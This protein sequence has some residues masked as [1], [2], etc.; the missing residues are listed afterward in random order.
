ML[1]KD[2][3][4]ETSDIRSLLTDLKTELIEHF[5]D[6]GLVEVLQDKVIL[7]GK[8]FAA[9]LYAL[10]PDAP[11]FDLIIKLDADEAIEPYEENELSVEDIINILQPY[12]DQD[13]ASQDFTDKDVAEVMDEL[14][15]DR[16]EARET[17]KQNLMESLLS[18]PKPQSQV[19][20][21]AWGRMRHLAGLKRETPSVCLSTSV[22]IPKII[23]QTSRPATL[24][25]KKLMRSMNEELPPGFKHGKYNHILRALKREYG[26]GEDNEVVYKTAWRIYDAMRGQNEDAS[27]LHDPELMNEYLPPHF[28]VQYPTILAK[29]EKHYGNDRLGLVRGAWK[30]FGDTPDADKKMRQAFSPPQKERGA[31]V[32]HS[33][34]T[35]YVK[36]ATPPEE[37]GEELKEG[38]EWK[39]IGKTLND[40][41]KGLKGEMLKAEIQKIRGEYK[42]WLKRKSA[43][44]DRATLDK[45][46]RERLKEEPKPLNPGH[47]DANGVWTA[48]WLKHPTMPELP[49]K[50]PKSK[51]GVKKDYLGPA[52]PSVNE[53]N[54]PSTT[55]EKPFVL[56]SKDDYDA[57]SDEAKEKLYHDYNAYQQQKKQ[58]QPVDE[59]RPERDQRGRKR[60]SRSYTDDPR[61]TQ[62][63][64]RVVRGHHNKRSEGHSASVASHQGEER[65]LPRLTENK[66][67]DPSALING[68]KRIIYHK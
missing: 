4:K 32:S 14:L 67:I 30:Y 7:F 21:E 58:S 43:P 64:E 48:D 34:P 40:K 15:K 26:A 62:E 54:E 23:K 27:M 59:A 45:Q 46:D 9:T 42:D 10:S 33:A 66:I 2:Y 1:T 35:R 16:P 38:G 6:L 18:A 55:E 37:S 29:M 49:D 50:P 68:I 44:T 65:R 3:T 12:Y 11:I 52:D 25:E 19:L 63:N 28:R 8:T 51:H 47:V 41:L 22:A 56:P 31:R 61:G 24:T 13:Y 39:D 5:P 20:N 60:W 53:D 57:M 17:M 36:H